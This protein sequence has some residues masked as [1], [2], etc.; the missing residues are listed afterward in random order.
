MVLTAKNVMVLS[1][2][3]SNKNGKSCGENCNTNTNNII[4]YVYISYIKYLFYIKEYNTMF[5]AYCH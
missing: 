4:I 3:I 2:Q 5:K 1:W